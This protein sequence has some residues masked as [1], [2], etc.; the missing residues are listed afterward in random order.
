MEA[1]LYRQ[2]RLITPQQRHELLARHFSETQRKALER[3][4]LARRDAASSE[5]LTFT[6]PHDKLACRHNGDVPGSAALR[7]KST[8]SLSWRRAGKV[9]LISA[10][11][12]AG[13]FRLFTRAVPDALTATG[14][15]EILND[16][17]KRVEAA[18]SEDNRPGDLDGT[19]SAFERAVR[20]APSSLEQCGRAIGLSFAFVIPAKYWVG[21]EL[22]SPRFSVANLKVGL[23]AWHRLH[24]ARYV[25][26]CGVSNRHSIHKRNN[27][28]Q[29]ERAWLHL[30]QEYINIWSEAGRD[31][32]QIEEQ[33][34]RWEATRLR[35]R[36][37]ALRAH[38]SEKQQHA[39]SSHRRSFKRSTKAAAVGRLQLPTLDRASTSCSS[40][41]AV[42]CEVEALLRRWQYRQKRKA[43]GLYGSSGKPGSPGKSMVAHGS[44]RKAG[45]A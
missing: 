6:R 36:S 20:E 24:S 30:R 15:V 26:H 29:L 33:L 14:F 44:P 2:L 28:V 27:P 18:Q 11:G 41:R 7:R 45:G 5:T 9:N 37:R 16:I 35:Y 10:K 39:S 40:V 31:R 4:I 38:S 13:P 21:R 8:A 19:G 32:C 3:W 25:V 1:V 42:T 17:Q 12:K 43:S 22:L 34:L 23:K